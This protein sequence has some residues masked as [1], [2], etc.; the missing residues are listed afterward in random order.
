[1]ILG[2]TWEFWEENWWTIYGKSGY[3]W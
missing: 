1:M 3:Y 2:S